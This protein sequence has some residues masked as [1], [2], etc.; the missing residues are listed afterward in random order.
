MKTKLGV[1]YLLTLYGIFSLS[2][3]KSASAQKLSLGPR[4]LRFSLGLANKEGT[5][6][7]SHVSLDIQ[8]G[9]KIPLLQPSFLTLYA[10]D[11]SFF[12]GITSGGELPYRPNAIDGFHGAGIAAVWN[13]PEKTQVGIGLG[14]YTAS[15][16]GYSFLVSVPAIR[17]SGWGGRAFM[18]ITTSK[19]NFMEIA[20]VVPAS[21]RFAL[22]Q[23]GFGIRF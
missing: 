14:K 23:V 8:T 17:K 19:Y 3:V 1:I 12:A 7:C 5:L 9:R 2:F 18:R 22:T 4:P 21:N 15:S 20:H 13:L 16:A 11:G 10:E 6:I